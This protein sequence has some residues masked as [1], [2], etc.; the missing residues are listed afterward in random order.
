MVGWFAGVIWNW[1]NAALNESVLAQLELQPTDRVLD[2]GFGGGYLL[3]RMAGVV[4]GGSLAGI[5]I[6][7]GIVSAGKR[8]YSRAV[9]AGR[10]DLRCAAV[11]AL[12]F[13]AGSFTKACSVNSIFYWQDAPKGI[14]EIYRVLQGGGKAVICFTCRESIEKKGFSRHIHLYDHEAVAQLMAAGGFSALRAVTAADRFRQ[15]MSVIG[16][17]AG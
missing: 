4:T 15:Y 11:E 6:S 3:S 14:N 2:I 10:L 5:D 1:R 16:T 13:A 17:K 7:P 8:R 9:E 12:P